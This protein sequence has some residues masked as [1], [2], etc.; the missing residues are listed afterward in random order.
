M[1]SILLAVNVS[2]A[3]VLGDYGGSQAPHAPK[4]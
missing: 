2:V 1:H 4:S 3:E